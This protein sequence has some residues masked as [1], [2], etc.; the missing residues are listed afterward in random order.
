MNYFPATDGGRPTPNAQRPTPTWHT[1]FCKVAM[2]CLFCG[3]LCVG[4]SSIATSQGNNL[5]FSIL[6]TSFYAGIGS[7]PVPGA[8]RPLHI[9][10]YPNTIIPS[11][12]DA[13]MRLSF[14][15]CVNSNCADPGIEHSYGHLSLISPYIDNTT[16]RGYSALSGTTPFKFLPDGPEPVDSL[17]YTIGDLVLSSSK[18]ARHLILTTRNQTGHIQLS[19]T[20]SWGNDDVAR[21]IVKPNGDIFLGKQNCNIDIQ[22][23]VNPNSFYHNPGGAYDVIVGSFLGVGNSGVMGNPSIPDCNGKAGLITLFGNSTQSFV[24]LHNVDGQLRIGHGAPSSI[25]DY[26]SM[27]PATGNI[28][29]GRNIDPNSRYSGAVSAKFAVSQSL[30]S[31]AWRNAP[32]VMRVERTGSTNTDYTLLSVGHDTKEMFVVKGNGKVEI[33][34]GT[35]NAAGRRLPVS[36]DNDYLLSVDGKVVS[37]EF[38]VTANSEWADYVFADD[39]ALM[40]LEKLR[41]YIKEHHRLPDVPP[42]AEVEQRGI[43]IGD[44]Q[45][46]MLKK[47][48]ELTLYMLELKSENQELQQQLNALRQ[49]LTEKK[50]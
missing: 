3:W 6:P 43:N 14:G 37:R 4:A 32:L 39:Y 12:Q 38:V 7:Y 19:T 2:F 13:T 34:D 30:W 21:M 35:G 36:P 17:E 33:G 42:A 40:P 10:A 31:D 23:G 26:I 22:T 29:V 9:T 44:M 16:R 25:E 1:N 24:N 20:S 41:G 50:P 11:Y 8:L 45:T 5:T 27:A 28:A 48:E 47:I 15:V 49:Q 18:L 46:V